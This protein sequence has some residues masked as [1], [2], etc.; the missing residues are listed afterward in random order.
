MR[1]GWTAGP[2]GFTGK[3]LVS[4]TEFTSSAVRHL[5]GIALAGLELRREWPRLDGAVGMWLWT[6]PRARR[7]GSVAV[8]TGEQALREFVRLPAHA[9]IMRKYRGRG[10][11]RA[12]RWWTE[13][14]DQAD[15]WR[16]AEQWLTAAPGSP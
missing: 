7:A 5:P 6:S 8:W 16:D 13:D 12:T 2:A 1:T 15:I 14:H 4:V 3:V 10:V 11:T 9:A